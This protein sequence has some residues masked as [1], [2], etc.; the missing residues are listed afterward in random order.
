MS[1]TRRERSGSNMPISDAQKRAAVAYNRRRDSITIRPSKDDGGVVRVSQ[2][3]SISCKPAKSACGATAS[4]HQT[5]RIRPTPDTFTPT[6]YGL[7]GFLRSAG[8]SLLS[9]CV[10]CATLDSM[11]LSN[12]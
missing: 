4:R 3:R 11:N 2:C 6:G 10:T 7:P 9:G 8:L 5:T 12:I 1:I